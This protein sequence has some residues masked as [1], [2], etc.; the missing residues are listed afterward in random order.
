MSSD[1]VIPQRNSLV[2]PLYA[3]LEVLAFRD[4]LLSN[5]ASRL[6][7]WMEIGERTLNNNWRMESDSSSLSPIIR[8]VKPGLIKRAFCPVTCGIH[9]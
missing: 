8:F 3:D 9:S 4:V 7:H 1:S 6:L 2:V 5:S